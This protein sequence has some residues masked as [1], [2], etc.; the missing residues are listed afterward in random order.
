MVILFRVPTF[1]SWGRKPIEEIDNTS[2]SPAKMLNFPFSSVE[3]PR[4]PPFTWMVALVTGLPSLLLSTV[5]LTGRW[6]C[7]FVLQ[8]Q[9]RQQ[10]IRS[11]ITTR[12]GIL[13]EGLISVQY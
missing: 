8:N 7:A 5:P 6:A 1:C 10:S 2:L 12:S 13:L 4:L 3:V 11:L 9:H